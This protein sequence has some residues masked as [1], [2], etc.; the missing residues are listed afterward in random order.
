MVSNCYT[1]GF[2][3]SRQAY[4][5]SLYDS[6]FIFHCVFRYFLPTLR[7]EPKSLNLILSACLKELYNINF[8]QCRNGKI[9]LFC[10]ICSIISLGKKKMMPP[11]ST[12]SLISKW[13]SDKVSKFQIQPSKFSGLENVYWYWMNFT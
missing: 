4:I 11:F 3:Y 7:P 8:K 1:L 10:Q 13:N 12:V 2:G 5:V 6:Q 9:D